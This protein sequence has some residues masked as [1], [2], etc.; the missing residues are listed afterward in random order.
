M[1][2]TSYLIPHTSYIIHHTSYLMSHTS[3]LIPHT[4]YLIPHHTFCSHAWSLH[5]GCHTQQLAANSRPHT[6]AASS[7]SRR[8]PTGIRTSLHTV[9]SPHQKLS[10]HV[11]PC[12][13]MS[14]TVA[15][16]KIVTTMVILDYRL[17]TGKYSVIIIL[18][19][20]FG[21]HDMITNPT[22]YYLQYYSNTSA[23]YSFRSHVLRSTIHT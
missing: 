21:T 20:I 16:F 14:S 13:P 2:H 4:S 17:L 3:Y 8:L 9:E 22:R 11:N 1:P 12:Q 6:A 19:Q 15:T 23:V 10:T 18:R 5:H 7:S